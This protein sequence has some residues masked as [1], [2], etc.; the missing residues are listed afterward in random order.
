MIAF[1][2]FFFFFS[3]RRRHTRFDCDWSSDV[4]SSD[5]D[6]Q[7]V[8]TELDRQFTVLIRSHA[9]ILASA[10][11][12][13][14]VELPSLIWAQLTQSLA[15]NGKCELE[16]FGRFSKA[17]DFG[18]LLISFDA[19]IVMSEL[20]MPEMEFAEASLSSL[21]MLA[22]QLCVPLTAPHLYDLATAHVSEDA[23]GAWLAATVC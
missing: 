16:G 2:V 9:G 3:S 1:C 21:S 5:L 7:D 22:L 8:V 19:D 12:R 23:G 6:E 17:Y 13:M 4:C 18:E 15:L 20:M 14:Y 10:G 11:Y